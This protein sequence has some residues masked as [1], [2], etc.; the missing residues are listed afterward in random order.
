MIKLVRPIIPT[1][2]WL[3]LNYVTKR[4][5]GIK[6]NPSSTSIDEAELPT[7]FKA[8]AVK[9]YV[10]REEMLLTVRYGLII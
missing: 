1:P 8:F 10:K 7:V 5:L 4:V 6:G 2:L 9:L 3:N